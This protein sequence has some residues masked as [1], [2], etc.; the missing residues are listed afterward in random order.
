MVL[1]RHTEQAVTF[2]GDAGSHTVEVF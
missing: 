1:G 2:Q